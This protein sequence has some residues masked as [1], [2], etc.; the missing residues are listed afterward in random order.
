[1][2]TYWVP[3][4]PNIKGISCHLWSF[5]FHICKWCLIYMIQQAYKYVSLHLW[6]CLTF[7]E[8]KITYI[9]KSSG[10]GLK[11]SELPWEQN[12]LQPQVFFLQN[13]Q[14]AKFQWSALQIGQDS[15]IYILVDCMTSSVISF[16][17]FTQL[18]LNI[19]GTN[20]GICKQ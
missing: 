7:Y 14:H 8:L 2:A 9:L 10:W 3:D 16:A 6:P 12:V 18:R 20:A 13:Y 5:H 4:L 19:S 17:Y 15:S 11:K 1:M